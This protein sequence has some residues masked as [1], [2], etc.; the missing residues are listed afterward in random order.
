MADLTD[1]DAQCRAKVGM[2]VLRDCG[3]EAV[4]ACDACG[5]PICRAHQ[6]PV[7]QG[8][9]CP[10]CA[11]RDEQT[12]RVTPA[13]RTARRRSRWY[14]SHR[15]R[16]YYYGGYGHRHHYYSDGDYRTFDRG[17][18]GEAEAPAEG[19]AEEAG[20]LAEAE[21]PDAA[22]GFDDADA[23]DFGPGDFDES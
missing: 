19:P 13:A 22:D 3:A 14:R 21:D 20:A 15:Y 5:R 10:E 9:S 12:A 17:E 2:L 23:D 7:A 16:P 8:V 1:S 4:A 6:C 11:A 18:A